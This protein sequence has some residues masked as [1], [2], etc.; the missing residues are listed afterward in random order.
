MPGA[1][2]DKAIEY[3]NG[4]QSIVKTL[5]NPVVGAVETSEPVSVAEFVAEACRPCSKTV[6]SMNVIFDVHSNMPPSTNLA[7]LL[8]SIASNMDN[9][10]PEIKFKNAIP[11]ASKVDVIFVTK[12]NGNMDIVKV[13]YLPRPVNFQMASSLCSGGAFV[14]VH[15]P[16]PW[17]VKKAVQR[18][19]DQLGGHQLRWHSLDEKVAGGNGSKQAWSASN[20]ELEEG[21]LFINA[22]APEC[23]AQNEQTLWVLINIKS[24]SGAPIAGWPE[25][26]VRQMCQNK[27]KGLGGA[28]SMTEFPLHTYSLKPFLHSVLLPFI[29]PLLMNYGVLLLGCPGV[30]KT[31]FVI[32]LCM[33][34]GRFHVRQSG[35]AGLKPG[36]RRAKSLDNFR[37]RAPQVQEGL[38]LD[39]PSRSKVNIADLKSFL[40]ADE[41]GTVESRYNDA[42]LIRNQLRAYASNDLKELDAT[43]K[44]IG[45]TLPAGRFLLLLDELF[46]GEKEK[47]VLAVLKRAIIFLFTESALYLRLPS[48]DKEGIVHRVCLEDIHKDLLA[49]KDKPQYGKYKA[50]IVETGPTFDAEVQREQAMV[51]DAMTMMSKY[52]KL[53]D[54]V[55]FIN[56]QLQDHLFRHQDIRV[57]PGSQTPEEGPEVAWG[58]APV[59]PIGTDP[60]GRFRRPFVYPA[61]DRRVRSKTSP[62]S[63]DLEGLAQAAEEALAKEHVIAEQVDAI[64]L[65]YVDL[66]ADAEAAAAMGLSE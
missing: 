27:S 39:D 48:E 22:H 37:H 46:A 65:D 20:A 26:K 51:D 8:Q 45:T 25:A 6:K 33:A 61:P 12:V 5:N 40:T 21:I 30:G 18:L 32:I 64:Q 3:L 15:R 55:Q 11:E 36:W 29:Y 60:P 52:D 47:D 19:L 7:E 10:P 56:G 54:Y 49:E 28:M 2:M 42:R 23:D 17:T 9:I 34:L 66:D 1:L 14:P 35:D 4:R 43:E 24:D 31:P 13:I 16:G 59:P 57:I 53:H 44:E 63:Q 38:F 50:G 41:D 62:A 58:A